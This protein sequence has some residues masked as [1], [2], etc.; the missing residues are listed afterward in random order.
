MLNIMNLQ[1]TRWLFPS[2]ICKVA[3]EITSWFAW[4]KSSL[5]C[6]QAL[7][8][9]LYSFAWFW[10]DQLLSELFPCVNVANDSPVRQM[11]ITIVPEENLAKL[12]TNNPQA[13]VSAVQIWWMKKRS[14][15]QSVCRIER[16]RLLR[17]ETS[18]LSLSSWCGSD[19]AWTSYQCT[20]EGWSTD[21]WRGMKVWDQRTSF[22]LRVSLSNHWPPSTPCARTH[23]RTVT[24]IFHCHACC[25]PPNW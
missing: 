20:A 15:R 1:S 14:Q 6:L 25:L 19:C 11:I 10:D 13:E 8:N 22:S 7:F 18:S 4:R 5:E 2:S 9:F 16:E 12:Q 23:G 17:K 24:K 3:V 21:L